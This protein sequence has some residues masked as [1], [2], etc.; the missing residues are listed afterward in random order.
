MTLTRFEQLRAYWWNAKDGDQ[1][2]TLRPRY[3]K[4]LNTAQE[5]DN[6]LAKQLKKAA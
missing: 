5:R 4:P 6:L 3:T 1:T 2:V